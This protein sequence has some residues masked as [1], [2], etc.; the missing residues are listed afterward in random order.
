MNFW[1]WQ[2]RQLLQTLKNDSTPINAIA[3]S[4]NQKHIASSADNTIKLWKT[5]PI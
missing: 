4:P 2:N 1:D 3:I 5:P